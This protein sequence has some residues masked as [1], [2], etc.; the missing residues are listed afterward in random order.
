M[1][2]NTR[3]RS[4]ADLYKHGIQIQRAHKK[5]LSGTNDLG[6]LLR[7]LRNTFLERNASIELFEYF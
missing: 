4:A 6:N 2:C 1:R 5:Y 3:A 7:E